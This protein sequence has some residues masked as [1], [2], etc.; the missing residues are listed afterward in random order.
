LE[1]IKKREK[2][3]KF[4]N[5]FIY[6]LLENNDEYKDEILANWQ[7]NIYKI[8]AKILLDI[9][10]IIK[11]ICNSSKLST[12]QAKT[13]KSPKSENSPKTKSENSPK[14]KKSTRSETTPVKKTA[15][16]LAMEANK[17]K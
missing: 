16:Q 15:R 13:K 1:K 12:S 17:K 4:I 9:I 5:L 11:K 3:P 2:N 8:M 6:N 14:T 10:K 7:H